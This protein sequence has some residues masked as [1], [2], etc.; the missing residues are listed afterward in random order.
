VV[1][2]GRPVVSTFVFLGPQETVDL[3]WRMRGGP[4][5]TGGAVVTVTPTIVPGSSS[6]SASSSC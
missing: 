4:G 5:Q 6:S 3:A 2:D 1:H